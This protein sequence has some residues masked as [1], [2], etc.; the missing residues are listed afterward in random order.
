[1]RKK[2]VWRYYCDFCKKAGCSAYHIRNHEERCTM[3]PNRVCGMCRLM[4]QPQPELSV[5]IA[6][7]PPT[8]IKQEGDCLDW[9]AWKSD[10][11]EEAALLKLREASGNCPACILATL[12]QAKIPVPMVRGFDYSAESKSI[13]ADYYEAQATDPYQYV[14]M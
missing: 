14:T 4:E 1:M 12:R 13:R 6:L 8:I 7:L 5:L 10:V 9:I 2:Q 3:N 11:D